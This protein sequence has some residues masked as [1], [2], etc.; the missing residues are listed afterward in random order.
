MILK[1]HINLRQPSQSSYRTFAS[2]QKGHSCPIAIT[3][4]NPQ[5]TSGLLSV[6]NRLVL[7]VLEIHRNEIIV[8]KFLSAFFH[9]V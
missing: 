4:P 3:S 6:I 2:F 5:T 9:A 8:D 1:A 7:P